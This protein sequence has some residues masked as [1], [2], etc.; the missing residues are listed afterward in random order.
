M[1]KPAR[2]MLIWFKERRNQRIKKLL[3][4]HVI[5]VYDATV[6]A[7]D[8]LH[9]FQERENQ[10]DISL[11]AA[12]NRIIKLEHDADV[13]EEKLAS[14]I[15][16]GYFPSTIRQNL[17]RV[18]KSDDATINL[19]KSSMKT[20]HLLIT[21]DIQVHENI[22]RYFVKLI[23]IIHHS[24]NL[25][26]ISIE[27]L[28]IDD[29]FIL[30]KKA[31]VEEHEREADELF[32]NVKEKSLVICNSKE[33]YSTLFSILEIATDLEM[34]SDAVRDTAEYLTVIVKAG[35]AINE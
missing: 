14:E 32:L 2:S 3:V 7:Q 25:V 16:K 33:P 29:A 23:D 8:F 15:A 26:W 19:L 22:I 1:N 13:I 10:P 6:A 9:L 20:L 12:I 17:F 34:A 31:E 4:Q 35:I 21:T 11:E 28:G 24:V 30:E 5:K 18:L 27:K